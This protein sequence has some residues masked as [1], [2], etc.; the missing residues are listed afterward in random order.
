MTRHMR[1]GDTILSHFGGCEVVGINQH[2]DAFRLA[3]GYELKHSHY[4]VAVEGGFGGWRLV[5][6]GHVLGAHRDIS[7]AIS[8]ADWRKFVHASVARWRIDNE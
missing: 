8:N 7:L 1:E 4:D 5:Q 2:R 3:C 6:D